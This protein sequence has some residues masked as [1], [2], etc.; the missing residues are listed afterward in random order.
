MRPL[1]PGAPAHMVQSSNLSAFLLQPSLTVGAVNAA[2]PDA[3]L[4]DGTIAVTLSPP[5]TED[6]EVLLQLEPRGG[7]DSAVLQPTIPGAAVF[8][9]ADF[10]FAF[11]D[12]APGTY[13]V[14]ARI[15]GADSPVQT[16][17][18]NGS[19]TFGEITGPEV[20]VP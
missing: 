3:G 18:T 19:P 14:I 11:S 16:D 1:S 5:V 15:D 4:H 9:L 10:T 13:I 6:Q 12:L 2:P 7:G 8:P 17:Q 20:R